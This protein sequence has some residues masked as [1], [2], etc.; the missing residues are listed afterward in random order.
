MKKK[1][2]LLSLI[3]CISILCFSQED[4]KPPNR[5]KIFI[6]CKTWNCPFDYIRSEIKFAD[7]VNDRFAANVF[8]MITA[9]TTGSGG[10][11]YKIYFEGLEEFKS[12]NDT[13]SYF[14]TSVETDDEDRKKMVQVLKLG[15]MRYV[16]RTPLATGIQIS[17]QQAGDDKKE[18]T[19]TQKDKWNAWV[20]N[21]G[22]NGYFSGNDNYTSS[23]IRFRV[24]GAR[25][26]EK[27]KLRF[28]A[29]YSKVRDKYIFNE[30]D[31][32]TGDLIS[33][34]TTKNTNRQTY[35]S[36]IAALSLNKHWSTGLF[37]DFE[38]STFSNIKRA[39]SLMPALEYSIY[40]Y[41]TFTTKY[42]G[43]LY[44]IGVISNSYEDTTWRNKT[45][46]WLAQQNLS[47]D[48]SFN[49]KWGTLSGSVY[50]SNYFFDWKWFNYG[51][52]ANGDFRILKGLSVNFYGG[53]SITHDQVALP[54]GNATP[55]QV[56]IRQRVLR[57]TFDYYT[58]MGINY[59]FGSIY[60][61]VVNPRLGEAGNY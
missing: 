57:N 8:V 56:L 35:M 23:N 37:G 31:D 32:N 48:F 3:S 36:S 43:F 33:S 26:T 4:V 41:K 9:S 17:A 21:T 39:F 7:Y 46:E 44:K 59:R 27:L 40:P 2:S 51:V 24:S 55:T 12:L 42:M 47:F 5:L 34:D 52:Y 10:Q 38:A 49:Q 16:A 20:F 58:G 19:T 15:L 45:S 25:V 28:S 29:N 14:K 61:N 60:N 18:Q 50:W 13:L 1:L 54:K 11:S 22:V 6:D 53:F 30:Y